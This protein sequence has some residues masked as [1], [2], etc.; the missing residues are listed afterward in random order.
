MNDLFGTDPHLLHRRGGPDTSIAAA[1]AV[2]TASLEEAIHK[3]V[4][5]SGDEGVI[6]SE[7]IK[8]F[9]QAPY[10]ITQR[11]S[12]LERKGYIYYKGDTRKG[13]FGRQQRVL[14]ANRRMNPREVWHD[15]RQPEAPKISL[16]EENRQLKARI[17][18]LESI[19]ND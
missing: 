6:S 3:I 7:L 8:S 12:G 14:R 18:E 2:D 11:Y 10:S 19:L 9:P 15:R 16:K 5:A 17:A 4:V 1:E 13:E